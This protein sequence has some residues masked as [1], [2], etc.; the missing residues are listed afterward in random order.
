MLG[1]VLRN[2]IFIAW[3]YARG[4]RWDSP[5]WCHARQGMERCRRDPDAGPLFEE[6]QPYIAAGRDLPGRAISHY[7]DETGWARDIL[8][9]MKIYKP[10]GNFSELNFAQVGHGIGYYSAG[11]GED[12]PQLASMTG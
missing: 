8:P 9:L 1:Y 4:A 10:Y 12:A 6:M 3:H 5:F 11:G 7:T 2:S